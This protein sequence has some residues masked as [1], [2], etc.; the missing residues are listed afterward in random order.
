MPIYEYACDTCGEDFEV[1]QKFSDAPLKRHTC[2]PKSVVRRKLSLTAF[3]LKGGGWYSEGYAKGNGNGAAA[4]NGKGSGGSEAGG[5]SESG[6]S[7]IPSS[8]KGE[9]KS[10]GASKEE[11]KSTGSSQPSG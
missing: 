1:I 10:T 11:S 8:S 9:S 6:T 2:A 7:A 3:Q 5:K 4:G